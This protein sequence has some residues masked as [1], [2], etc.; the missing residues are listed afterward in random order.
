MNVAH[1]ISFVG[2]IHGV[3]KS[4]ICNDICNQ[5]NLS[6]LSA[7]ELIKWAK[8]NTDKNNKNVKDIPDTQQ[9]LIDGI[10]NAVQNNKSYLLDGH[11]CLLDANN[12]VIKISIDIFKEIAPSS[13]ILVIGDVAKIKKKLEER[14]QKEYSYDLLSQMQATEIA[15]AKELSSLLNL[16]LG[17]GSIDDT[18]EIIS[19]L[20]SIKA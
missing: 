11:Y 3:G 10:A 18:S 4:T 12:N 16:K 14:D 17:I 1:K 5:L 20:N 19:V 8:I 9:R 7:S 6:Y 15:Y 2:G 13:L